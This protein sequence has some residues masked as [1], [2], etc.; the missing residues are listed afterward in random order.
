MPRLIRGFPVLLLLCLAATAGAADSP[1]HW[2]G[3]R[4]VWDRK[5]NIVEL[6]GAATLVQSG[7]VL[8]ADEMRIDLRQRVVE[9][10]GHCLYL[11]DELVMQGQ[12]MEFNLDSRNGSIFGGRI[13]TEGF[14]LAGEQIS[15]L[16]A[17]RFQA[18]GAEYTTCKDCPQSWSFT[19]D[20]VDLT[21]GGYARMSGVRGKVGDVPVTELAS[22]M[23][24]Y[25]SAWGTL[26]TELV[27]VAAIAPKL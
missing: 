15:R 5:T 20:R 23:M 21:F 18:T 22:K 19:G 16:G 14:T 12:R 17:G 4:Q 1:L 6:S 25:S 11:S 8:S 27:V 2:S 9:A 3:R 24:V 10:R 26:M 13:S 7:E